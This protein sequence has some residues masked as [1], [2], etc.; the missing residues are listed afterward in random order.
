MKDL[1][2]E[3]IDVHW[4]YVLIRQTELTSKVGNIALPS[5]AQKDD[6][7]AVL[8]GIVIA[9]GPGKEDHQG[10][11]REMIY[12]VGDDVLYPAHWTRSF[13]IGADDYDILSQDRIHGRINADQRSP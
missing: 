2:A 13:V 3:Q 11:F 9:V 12:Q 8:R 7:H 1:K 10:V 6:A 5:S 4:D